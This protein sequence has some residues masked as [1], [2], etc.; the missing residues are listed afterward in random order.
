[1][2]GTGQYTHPSAVVDVGARIGARTK[3]WH[4]V[5]VMPGA[6]IGVDCV[7][8]QGCFIGNVTIGD[9]VRIQNNVSV[10]D[11]VTLE[12]NV[13]CGP[14]CVFT[15]VINPRSDVSRKDEYRPTIVRSGAS[16]GANATI[17]CGVTI[18]AYAFVG[19]GA[20]VRWD[21]PPYALVVGVPATRIGWMCACGERLPDAIAVAPPVH[22]ARCHRAYCAAGDEPDGSDGLKPIFR[23]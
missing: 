22:C 20:V 16:I 3:I 8:G 9:G 13:F 23:E 1:M 5:H 17:I 7:V 10:Y 18:G 19:A 6:V 14:S 15:N 4:F 2:P 21:V 11:G 12:D